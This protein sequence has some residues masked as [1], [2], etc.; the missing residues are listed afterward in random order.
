MTKV[1][2]KEGTMGITFVPFLS[3]MCKRLNSCYHSSESPL[4]DNK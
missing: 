1:R 4:E 3:E 2:S